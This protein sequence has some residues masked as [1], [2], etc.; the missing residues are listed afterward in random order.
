M[1]PGGQRSTR[2]IVEVEFE[3]DARDRGQLAPDGKRQPA[4]PKV[5]R[6]AEAQRARADFTEA[7]RR[8]DPLD[9]ARRAQAQMAGSANRGRPLSA[10]EAVLRVMQGG[11]LLATE[12]PT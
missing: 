10:T 8:P 2:G 6:P 3:I 5:A 7:D 9:I 4:P 12:A 1:T 11:G